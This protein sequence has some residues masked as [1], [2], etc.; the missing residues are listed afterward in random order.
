MLATTIA[1]T[2]ALLLA[3][4]L[5]WRV[6]QDATPEVALFDDNALGPL[7]EFGLW[8]AISLGPFV[9]LAQALV[10]RYVAHF[11]EWK[12]WGL[13]TGI[14]AP[15][16]LFVGVMLSSFAVFSVGGVCLVLA[17]AILPGLAFGLAQSSLVPTL[18]RERFVRWIWVVTNIGALILGMA[19]G[20]LV[21]S[22]AGASYFA[23][24]D[25]HFPF[26]PFQ[27]AAYWAAGWIVGAIVFSTLTGVMLV[28]MLRENSDEPAMDVGHK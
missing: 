16:I 20:S 11:A 27:S 7:L 9:G 23:T 26:Y 6:V 3:D 15:I 13:R 17:L 5:V 28:R 4:F 25:Y 1:A 18:E 10:L 14:L 12:A 8:L 19:C 24:A 2:A 22:V 21:T